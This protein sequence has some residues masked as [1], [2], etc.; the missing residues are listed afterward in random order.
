M[1]GIGTALNHALKTADTKSICT[2]ID[3]IVRRSPNVSQV[4]KDAGLDRRILYRSLRGKKGPT[5]ATVIRILRGVG[6]RLIV[7]FERQ[8]R[9]SSPN[10]F[11]QSSKTKEHLELRS[12]SKACAEY[13]TRAFE[14]DDLIEITKALED[15]LRAQEN[16]VEFAKRTSIRRSALY[17]AFSGS[18]VPQFS[19]VIHFLRALGLSLAVLPW[20]KMQARASADRHKK[21]N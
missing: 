6:F 8:P 1:S 5:L 19:T 11:G 3:T 13:L 4:A 14:N 18:H 2:A 21:A 15:T 16:V 9:K 7:N 10:R 20:P 17:R 12:D